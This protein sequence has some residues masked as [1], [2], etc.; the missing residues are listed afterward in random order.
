M[1]LNVEQPHG[2]RIG[3]LSSWALALVA[4]MAAATVVATPLVGVARGEDAED[5]PRRPPAVRRGED[6]PQR[7]ER[8]EG[9]P[10]RE[11]REGET[12]ERRRADGEADGRRRG[13]GETRERRRGDGEAD[14]RRRGEGETRERRR[15]DG[16]TRERRRGEGEREGRGG[17]I[18]AEIRQM[19]RELKI[20]DA[21]EQQIKERLAEKN[22]QMQAWREKNRARL[23]EAREA[24]RKAQAALRQL[25]Q[26][27]TEAA[28]AADAKVMAVFTAQQR[29]T[30]QTG[31]I[32]AMY[33]RPRGEDPMAL[34]NR[35]L[36]DIDILCEKAAAE[37][38]AAES[39]PAAEAEKA[40][41]E[42]LSGLQK[43]IHEDIL[44][45]DQRRRAPRP[46]G[47]PGRR[48]EGDGER[49]VERRR[50]GDR[51]RG[52]RREAA[53]GRREGRR[54]T[55]REGEGD[56]PREREGRRETRRE[57]EGDRPRER[58]GRREPEREAERDER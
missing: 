55:R 30:W 1:I 47:L 32:A 29:A 7:R 20:T 44:D 46:R 31:R 13:E 49:R 24:L 45:A 34:T 38:V 16:E 50:E 10:R 18:P 3:R 25:G 9:E 27:E 56:R 58:E 40:K 41:R 11:Q 48:G 6:A 51:G 42:I 54:E 28:K 36:D 15:G 53:E 57:G 43:K 26:E 2:P 37:L 19:M 22:R 52:E 8:A 5:E 14:G 12:R 21:Q 35:Q 4:C 17:R 39:K 23:A 33:H